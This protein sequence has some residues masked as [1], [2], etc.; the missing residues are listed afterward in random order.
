MY[1]YYKS[2]AGNTIA[3]DAGLVK[4]RQPL[5]YFELRPSSLYENL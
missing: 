2:I 5:K 4:T 1:S 3:G